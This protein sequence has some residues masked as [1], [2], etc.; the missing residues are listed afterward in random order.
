MK[1][2]Y[3]MNYN[4]L[5]CYDEAQGVVIAKDEIIRKPNMKVYNYLEKGI[6]GIM[7]ITIIYLLTRLLYFVDGSIAIIKTLNIMTIVSFA[8]LALYFIIFFIG[9]LAEKSKNHAGSLEVDAVGIKDIS[10]NGV[11]VGFKWDNIKMIVI[12][13]HTIN[14]IT[15]NTIY[16]CIDV[17]HLD[18]LLNAINRYNPDLLIIDKR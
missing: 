7:L 17:E 10:D 14:I 5:R 2:K 18:R 13:K 6:I 12:K 15:D 1:I 11:I 4:Y 3:N 9:Y 16:L 8:L